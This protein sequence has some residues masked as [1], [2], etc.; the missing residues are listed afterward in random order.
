MKIAIS[1]IKARSERIFEKVGLSKGDA[2]IITKV[3]LETEMRGVFTH[4]FLR[5][6][7]YVSCMESGGIKK[8][9]LERIFFSKFTKSVHLL[10]SRWTFRGHFGLVDTF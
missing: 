4:G 5:L 6:A 1:E 10:K 8:Y 3:L 7:R 2:Q 9:R